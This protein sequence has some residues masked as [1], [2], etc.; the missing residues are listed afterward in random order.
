MPGI[1]GRGYAI[2][3]ETNTGAGATDKHLH[4]DEHHT[5]DFEK[6]KERGG[7]G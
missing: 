1:G 6:R 7:S 2:I 5:G 4:C 3:I